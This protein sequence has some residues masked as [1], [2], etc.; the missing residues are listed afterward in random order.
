MLPRVLP[1][2]VRRARHRARSLRRAFAWR[3]DGAH[4]RPRGSR[5]WSS[6]SC[7]SR[8]PG[9]GDNAPWWWHAIS[10][11]M[12]QLARAAAPA[13]PGGA[14]RR[15]GRAAELPRGAA[16]ARHAC[17]GRGDRPLR[18]SARRPARAQAPDRDRPLADGRA[19]PASCSR[20]APRSRCRCS[21]CGA[22]RTGSRPPSTPQAFA[23][24]VPHARGAG[25]GALRPLPAARAA[26]PGHAPAGR[27]PLR[28]ARR[29]V[30]ASAQR[31][32]R[33]KPSK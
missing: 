19:I 3:R 6:G 22:A 27:V 29:R 18:A 4:G 28:A 23:A 20:A 30:R 13:E 1:R 21:C 11:S 31:Q 8:P 24:A 15:E 12:D 9:L 2:A 17:D 10:G 14:P 25:A 33:R 7:W 32:A 16:R 5:R 26:H